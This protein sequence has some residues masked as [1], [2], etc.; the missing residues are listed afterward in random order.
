M[1]LQKKNIQLSFASCLL[2]IA[3][4][5]PSLVQFSHIF[6]NHEHNFCGD[7]TTHLHEQK[8][9]C[10]LGDFHFTHFH[11]E[12]TISY[13]TP[14]IEASTVV[15]ITYTSRRYHTLSTSIGLRGPPTLL[16]FSI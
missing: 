7:V 13:E 5:F 8:L 2:A 11:F 12:E 6:E 1:N 9:D 10:D 14:I 4:V 3:L 15:E 16:E